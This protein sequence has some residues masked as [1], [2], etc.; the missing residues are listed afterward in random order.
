MKPKCLIALEDDYV[1][2]TV[3]HPYTAFNQGFDARL[4]K[5]AKHK[6]P[7]RFGENSRWW[8]DGYEEAAK[9]SY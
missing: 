5:I 4:M 7:Y 8:A 1:H 9:E 6:N 3:H 2:D